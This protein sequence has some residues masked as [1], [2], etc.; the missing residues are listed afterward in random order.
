MAAS[1]LFLVVQFDWPSP[2]DPE[3][4]EAAKKLHRAVESADWIEEHVAGFGGLGGTLASIWIFGL[5]HYADLDRLFSDDSDPVA[6]AY[7]GFF[8]RMATVE[9]FVREAVQ[10]V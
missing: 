2:P 8:R 1:K 9:D 10:F 7:A 4:G 5:N 3:A 6:S